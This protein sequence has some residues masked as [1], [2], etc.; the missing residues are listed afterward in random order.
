MQSTLNGVVIIDKPAGQSS[1]KVLAQVKTLFRAA[2]AGHSGTL[3]PF[4]T[5]VLVCCL[6]Q[7]TRLARFFLHGQKTYEAVLVL[8]VETDTQDITGRVIGRTEMPKGICTARIEEVFARFKGDSMQQPPA[9]SALKHQGKPLY[10]LAR[11]GKPVQK[12]PRPVSVHQIRLLEVE[13][14]RIRFSVTCSAGTYVRTLCA[15]MGQAFGC[16]GHLAEL[17]RTASSWFSIE[18]ANTLASLKAMTPEDRSKTLI[19][20]A[21]ALREMP[22]F[23][24]DQ[25]LAER[26][27]QGQPLTKVDIPISSIQGASV[28][29][30]LGPIRV[31]D[32]QQRLRA[33]VEAKP[34]GGYNYCCV[35][36]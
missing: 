17:R 23:S 36:N 32:P 3:D 12:P 10:R 13:L 22:V 20:M 33:V 4:A 11:E 30:P 19:N 16:G 14:P 1:A 25:G 31:L 21:D 28:N 7:A 24:A 29:V 6:N 26:I 18:V 2:K 15:D 9:F 27:A 35:F 34:D 5:G 8:G